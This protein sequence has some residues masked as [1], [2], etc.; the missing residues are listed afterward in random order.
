[1]N[2]VEHLIRENRST[3]AHVKLLEQRIIKLEDVIIS[4]QNFIKSQSITVQRLK[5]MNTKKL[6]E[7]YGVHASTIRRW[8]R[9]GQLD[10]NNVYIN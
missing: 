3:Q 10:K 7:V 4:L 1:M 2:T 9:C 8:K 5:A 6:G